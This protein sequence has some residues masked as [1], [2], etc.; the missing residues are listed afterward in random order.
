M[1]VQ[2][3][4]HD[5][6]S[7]HRRVSEFLSTFISGLSDLT[8]DL[9][10]DQ[11][12]GLIATKQTEHRQLSQESSIYIE[13][14]SQGRTRFNKRQDAIDMLEALEKDEFVRSVQE[15]LKESPQI[16]VRGTSMTLLPT[17]L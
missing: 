15:I 10:E 5:P 7:L 6:V 2:S 17:R 11:V 13:E 3:P 14:I 4:T 12:D 9:F 1:I 8:D 16:I